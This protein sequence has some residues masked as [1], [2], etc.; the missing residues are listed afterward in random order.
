MLGDEIHWSE[1]LL[2]FLLDKFLGLEVST[3]C[4]AADA[5]KP[6]QIG[7]AEKAS[8]TEKKRNVLAVVWRFW[9]PFWE[10]ADG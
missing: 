7:E 4:E 2:F 5:T 8:Q 10:D 6:S 9:S 3:S 1:G